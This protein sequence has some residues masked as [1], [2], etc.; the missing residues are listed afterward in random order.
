MTVVRFSYDGKVRFLVAFRL[1]KSFPVGRV[2]NRRAEFRVRYRAIPSTRIL[3]CRSMEIALHRSCSL[4]FVRPPCHNPRAEK[5]RVFYFF[6]RR[7]TLMDSNECFQRR[8]IASHF[9]RSRVM[10]QSFVCGL[11]KE[12]VYRIYLIAL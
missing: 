8:K 7:G 12:S 1:D 9:E 6:R 5:K 10:Y 4:H 3:P 2:V 11:E